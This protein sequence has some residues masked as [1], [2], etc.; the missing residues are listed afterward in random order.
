VYKWGWDQKRKIDDPSELS[1][2]LRKGVVEDPYSIKRKQKSQ[3]KGY[4]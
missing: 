2:S 4:N 1:I 3:F